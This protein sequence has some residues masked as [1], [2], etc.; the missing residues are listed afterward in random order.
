VSERGQ[1]ASF[2]GANRKIKSQVL[3]RRRL[4]SLRER[5]A[6]R[7]FPASCAFLSVVSAFTVSHEISSFVQARPVV[8]CSFND[9]SKLRGGSLLT[10]HSMKPRPACASLLRSFRYWCWRILNFDHLECPKERGQI[11]HIV[12]G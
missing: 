4:F 9:A 11:D 10:L 3:F 5:E 8:T 7:L 6:L 1:R 2:N 12:R